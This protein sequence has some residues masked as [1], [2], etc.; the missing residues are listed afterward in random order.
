MCAARGLACLIPRPV[1]EFEPSANA[2]AAGRLEERAN[3][4]FSLD[5]HRAALLHAA[6]R[7]IDESAR[8]LAP[9]VAEGNFRKIFPFADE[10]AREAEAALQETP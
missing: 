8:D 10:I 9:I 4:L 2:A 3:A 5:E 1:G 6:V 7:W